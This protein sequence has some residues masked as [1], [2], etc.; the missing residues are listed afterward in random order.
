MK[1]KTEYSASERPNEEQLKTLREKA[2]QSLEILKTTSGEGND[3]LGWIDLP[4]EITD[5]QLADIEQLAEQI[6]KDSEVF[7]V[8]GIGGSYLGAR[9]VIEALKHNFDT[10]L[11]ERKH[12]VILYAG[13]TLNA[14]YTA[15]LLDIL[16]KKDYSLCVISKSGTTTETAVTFRLLRNHLEKKYGHAQAIKRIV[17][18]TDKSRGILKSIADK[19]GYKTYVIPDNVGG[20]YSVLTPVG[21][22]PIAVAGFDIRKLTKGALQM[23]EELLNNADNENNIAI[24]YAVARNY[25]YNQGKTIELMVNYQT[26]LVYFNEWFKQLYGESEGKQH[27]GLFPASVTNTTDLHSMGQ[28]VQ[29]GQRLMFETVIH[30][31]NPKREINIAEQSVDDD[32]LNYLTKFSL[33]DINHKAEEGT[34]Q[35]HLEGGVS[36][37]QICIDKTDEYNIGQMIYF[38]ELA[39]AISG[40]M[41]GINP[42]DQPGVENYKKKMF[43]LLGKK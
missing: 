4:S 23:S 43:A 40:Y 32:S 3:Y 30:V 18:V 12:P 38:F 17:A 41:L 27:K 42:F 36:Q 31:D 7:V 15:D 1:I 26:N 20:R 8:A 10:L 13:N 34:R 2:V 11:S 33:T 25:L 9:M 16:D 24:Q 37:L 21:L 5:C 22:L 19:E 6:R 14:D 39:C 35:A 29:D 28:Y